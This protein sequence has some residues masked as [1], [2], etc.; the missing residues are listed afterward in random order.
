MRVIARKTLRD[1]W[2][3]E[4]RT[5][6]ELKA[7]FAE[8]E[9]GDWHNPADVKAKYGNASILRDGRV[10]FNIC[11]NNYRLVVWINYEFRTIYLRFI[12]THEEYDQIDAQTI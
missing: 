9:A 3:K 12:G 4:P 1:Y 7:W 8:A 10:V 6:Q 5:E 11:G 2:Q